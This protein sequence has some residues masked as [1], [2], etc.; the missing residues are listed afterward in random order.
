MTFRREYK[1][2]KDLRIVVVGRIKDGQSPYLSAWREI[3]PKHAD[4]LGSLSGA[5]RLRWLRD[6]IDEALKDT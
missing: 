2:D 1:G 5:R 4:Y 3:N 6:A